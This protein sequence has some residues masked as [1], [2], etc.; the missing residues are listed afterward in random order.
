[1]ATYSFLDVS[2]SITS[3][4]GQVTF[5]GEGIPEEGIT[6]T[7]VDTKNVMTLGADGAVMHSLHAANAYTCTIRLLKT[8]PKNATLM[9]MYNL[10][11]SSSSLHGTNVII[12]RDVS[13]G[14]I[15]TGANA[16]FQN[17]PELTYA[18]DGGYNEWT[19]DIGIGVPFL[20]TGTPSL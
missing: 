8:N 11:T 14:D 19:F 16:A 5:E 1:M 2:C 6:I 3:E 12:V 7:P 4:T 9:T 10:Q 17:P 15:F 18:I 20:G 13:R